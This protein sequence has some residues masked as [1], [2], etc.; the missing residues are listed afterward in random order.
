MF[1]AAGSWESW[2]VGGYQTIPLRSEFVAQ[3]V[4]DWTIYLVT[5][6]G[7]KIHFNDHMINFNCSHLFASHGKVAR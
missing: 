1:V 5:S 3:V 4:L 6:G 2:T 7:S